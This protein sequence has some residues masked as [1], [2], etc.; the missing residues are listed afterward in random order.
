MK[1]IFIIFGIILAVCAGTLCVEGQSNLNHF[2]LLF[3][4]RLISGLDPTKIIDSRSEQVQISNFAT[5]TNFEYTDN[6]I[7]SIR[8]M[9]KIT[10]SPLTNYP[11]I[12]NIFPYVKTNPG[13]QH[14]LVQ[15]RNTS[16]ADSKVFV[17]STATPNT[18]VFTATALHTDAS[19]AGTGRFSDAPI[20]HV[21]YCNGAETMVWGGLE[22]TPGYFSIFDGNDP[23]TSTVWIKDYTDQIINTLSDAENV[24]TLKRTDVA[25][26]NIGIGSVT[27]YIATRL[28][29]QGIKFDVGTANT[30]TGTTT[31]HFWNG[32]TLTAVTSLVDGTSSGGI[33]LAQDGTVSFDSTTS[34]SKVRI[35]EGIYGY[36]YRMIWPNATDTCTINTV[37]ID[38][39]FQKLVDFWDSEPRTILSFQIGTG[40]VFTDSTINVFKDEFSYDD[41]TGFDESTYATVHNKGGTGSFLAY[42]FNERIMG[43]EVK[44]IPDKNNTVNSTMTISTWNGV[45]WNAVSD[46]VDGTFTDSKTFR[47][48][49]IVTWT[50][51]DENVEFRRTIG[52]KKEPLYYYRMTTNNAMLG[53][54]SKLFVYYISGIPVQKPISSYKFSLF[55]Q[56][57]LW[58]F[59][60][61]KHER[62]KAIVSSVSTLNVFNGEEA[63]DPLFIGDDSEIQAAIPIHAR[64]TAGIKE[65]ILVLKNNS[66]YLITGDD[67]ETWQ[68]ITISNNIGC[69]APLTLQNSS[70]GLETAPL[71]S[72]QIAVWQGNGGIYAWDGTSIFPISDAISNYFDNTKQEAISLSKAHLSRGF[73]ETHD[74]NHYYHWLFSSKATSTN[75]LDTEM[76]FD[77]KRQG[78]FKIDR[79]SK[80]LQAGIGTIATDTGVSYAYAAV[81][82]GNLMR[83]NDGTT[84][85]G[86]AITSIFE[87]GDIPLAGNVMTEAKLRFLRFGMVGKSTTTNSVSVT[88][89]TDGG[90][91]GET[92]S[93]S[94]SRTGYRM[95]LPLKSRNKYGTF[96]R[97]RGTMTTNDETIGFEP[98]FL[99]GSLDVWREVNN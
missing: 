54:T 37:W 86:D 99:G 18:G 35:I 91:S 74:S 33:P 94:P 79:G 2:Q 44:F 66:A 77:I 25:H 80:L 72:K 81:D 6:G 7:R 12:H 28:P 22:N 11:R 36:F 17:F 83:L 13:E 49:G 38:E 40:T 43:L 82:S 39:P 93:M 51:R 47:Q 1:R 85:D 56:G 73:F 92:F 65:D 50:P 27:A 15:T 88:H 41:S 70:I 57:R 98:L 52:G 97:F 16:D 90:N 53:T 10:T 75:D 68:V 19:G 58:L 67:A 69:I 96:H 84:M 42:G 4:G 76:V 59:N 89:Y 48:S 46:L 87:T 14:V 29:I 31:V 26:Y 61:Q 21:V 9:S 95:A 5:L 34:T 64:T 23:S 8:G 20:G 24:A 55:S 3:D 32:S 78:W 30:N 45:E 71:Q 60:D 63:G 62:N